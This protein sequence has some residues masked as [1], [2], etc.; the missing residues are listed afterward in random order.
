M[1][2]AS[3]KGPNQGEG[4]DLTL[5]ERAVSLIHRDLLS[6]ALKPNTRL[7]V[8]E[9]AQR[10]SIGA[11]PIREA[12]SRLSPLG[13]VQPL[14]NR[15]FRA[16]PLSR[17]DLE[18]IVVARR[19]NEVGALRRAME[20]GNADW[21][22]AIVGALYRLKAALQRNAGEDGQE[23]AEFDHSH[24]TFHMTLIAACDS[25]R[26]LELSDMLYDQACRYRQIMMRTVRLTG[27]FYDEH[28]R[29][30]EKVLARDMEGACA[31]LSCHLG[32]SLSVVYPDTG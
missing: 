26:L 17:V 1:N 10:Y 29:L 7:R 15:G 30:A 23:V 32:I 6:G 24:K 20:L 14:G 25:G 28:A 31:Q 22:A 9:L 19:V 4:G 3:A 13:L 5:V 11:T 12:L 27:D 16:K 18:D 2:H 8:Q 21:E